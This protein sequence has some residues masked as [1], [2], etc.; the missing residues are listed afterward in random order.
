MWVVG[1]LGGGT[2]YFSH[3]NMLGMDVELSEQIEAGKA[4]NLIAFV[5]GG[6]LPKLPAFISKGGLDIMR[7]VMSQVSSLDEAVIAI[8]SDL[9]RMMGQIHEKSPDTQ[10]SYVIDVNDHENKKRIYDRV[11]GVY[12]YWPAGMQEIRNRYESKIAENEATIR[13]C[14]E[15]E[16][17]AKKELENPLLEATQR[18]D[19]ERSLRKLTEKIRQNK[20]EADDYKQT[21]KLYNAIEALW[22]WE[23]KDMELAAM[24]KVFGTNIYDENF[25]KRVSGAIG[26]EGRAKIET[27]LQ[28][29]KAKVMRAQERLHVNPSLKKRKNADGNEMRPEAKLD[30]EKKLERYKALTK[31]ARVLTNAIKKYGYSE[32]E[33]SKKQAD[34]VIHNYLEKGER[35]TR[36]YWGSHSL[37]DLAWE[38]A[39]AEVLTHLR[40]AF[41]RRMPIDI[42]EEN[43]NELAIGN[44]VIRLSDNPTNTSANYKANNKEELTRLT[45]MKL[46]KATPGELR[47]VIMGHSAQG[48][49]TAEPVADRSPH[50]VYQIRAPPVFDVGRLGEAWNKKI[51]TNVT[52][53]FA[54]RHAS[55]GFFEIQFDDLQATQTFLSSYYLENQANKRKDAQAK[56]FAERLRKFTPNE[57]ARSAVDNKDMLQLMHKLPSE[58][59]DELLGKLLVYNGVDTKDRA[60]INK[61]AAAIES[62]KLHG[63]NNGLK[64]MAQWCEEHVTPGVIQGSANEF[65]VL[66]LNDL[67]VGT[68]GR[69]LPTESLVNGLVGWLKDRAVPDTPLYIF[70][71]GDNGEPGHHDITNELNDEIRLSNVQ[72][73]EQQLLKEGLRKG[74]PEFEREANEYKAYLLDKRPIH[75]PQEQEAKFKTMMTPL[76]EMVDAI[77]AA[78]GQ[79]GNKFWVGRTRDES[80]D[81]EM[82]F[83]GKK[84]RFD[85][86]EIKALPGGDTSIGTIRLMG[87]YPTLAGHVNPPQLG[88]KIGTEA[89]LRFAADAHV[90]E[91][92]LSDNN[93]SMTGPSSSPINDFATL[94][95]FPTSQS[96]RGFGLAK[97]TM[98][99]PELSEEKRVLKMAARMITQKEM[100]AEGYIKVN[101]RIEKFEQ[102]LANVGGRKH[103]VSLMLKAGP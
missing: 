70:L 33:R 6:V 27:A 19:L 99:K 63:L 59:N 83:E 79:H 84:G 17:T 91:V 101:P 66:F 57:T 11:V 2:V 85:V 25:L 21:T 22:F 29:E 60:G 8:K 75:S 4:P 15:S 42:M 52:E 68:S 38:I 39:R 80:L 62:G 35:Y 50:F 71:G 53:M 92:V 98:E 96:L 72:K 13:D 20:E 9:S 12:R 67:H 30:I 26:V 46:N 32:I 95:G 61:L 88:D 100:I 93:A 41:G 51:K 40:N 65:M 73:Y 36:N 45:R 1:N 24:A 69:G 3:A 82:M 44:A 34:E 37:E 14:Q 77:F 86:I 54:R 56:L 18:N 10:I 48:T 16:M 31:Q 76:V 49:V 89:H 43:I 64:K 94:A 5:G 74:T 97:V 90:Y 58:L 102:E 81:A 28:E 87:I 78:S 47:F 55:S 103:E 23:H 7:A